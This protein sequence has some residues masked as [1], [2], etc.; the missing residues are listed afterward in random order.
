MHN[1]P[2][3]AWLVVAWVAWIAAC[4]GDGWQMQDKAAVGRPAPD[5]SLTD[6][7]GKVWR[8]SEL[9]GKAVF[10][11]FWATWCQPCLEEMPSMHNLNQRLP[12]SSFQLLSIIYNDRPEFAWRVQEKIGFTFPV[13]MDS[14]GSAARIYGLT[15]VPETYIVDANGILR[16]K[17]IGPRDWNTADSLAMVNEYLPQPGPSAE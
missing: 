5:F 12:A 13:L 3:T 4:G 11:N 2:R 17:I 10:I 16:R 15:G 14:D 9:R 7:D 6:I 8:L 1:A